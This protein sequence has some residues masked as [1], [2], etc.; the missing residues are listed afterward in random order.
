M[1]IQQHAQNLRTTCVR[2]DQT[3]LKRQRKEGRPFFYRCPVESSPTAEIEMRPSGTNDTTSKK[4]KRTLTISSLSAQ[5]C[6]I[7]SQGSIQGKFQSVPNC[8][9]LR[10]RRRRE[11]HIGTSSL[12]RRGALY[13]Q[14]GTFD[15]FGSAQPYSAIVTILSR[16]CFILEFGFPAIQV[17]ADVALILSQ[18]HPTPVKSWAI[19][20]IGHHR[21][22]GEWECT[23]WYAR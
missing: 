8:L 17:S 16:L 10:I 4:S 23:T 2:C 21:T 1:E 13:C 20:Q 22:Y 12:S 19:R 6:S 11:D 3:I 7:Y 9:A 14:H 18:F 15:R 5:G